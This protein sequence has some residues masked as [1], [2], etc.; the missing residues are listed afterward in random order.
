[1][2]EKQSNQATPFT[3]QIKYSGNQPRYVINSFLPQKEEWHN[4]QTL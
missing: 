4:Y 1:M 3:I 2:G